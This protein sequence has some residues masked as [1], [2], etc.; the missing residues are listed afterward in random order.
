MSLICILD[1]PRGVGKSTTAKLLAERLE[2]SGLSA[3]VF[4]KGKRD[5]LDELDNMVQHLRVLQMCSQDVVIIDRHVGTEIA[6]SYA[7]RRED[8]E[9][10]KMWAAVVNDVLEKLNA[11]NVILLADPVLLEERLK[12][13]GTRPPDLPVEQVGPAWY[14]AL[15]H[16]PGAYG[17]HVDNGEEDYE[18]LFGWL[19]PLLRERVEQGNERM[20]KEA[21]RVI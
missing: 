19:L 20:A 13:R 9:T 21:L 12:R 16:L 2:V 8:V 6:M 11:V 17:W 3:L 10:L 14:F 7:L 1:G 4:K 15:Q 5:D 18:D